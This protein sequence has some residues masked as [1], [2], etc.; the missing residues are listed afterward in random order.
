MSKTEKVQIPPCVSVGR[1]IAFDASNIVLKRGKQDSPAE[2]MAK[3]GLTTHPLVLEGGDNPSLESLQ[4][5]DQFEHDPS[6]SG[7]DS[8]NSDDSSGGSTVI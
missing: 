3:G 4:G 5:K 6:T 7:D 1:V 2:N 8:S